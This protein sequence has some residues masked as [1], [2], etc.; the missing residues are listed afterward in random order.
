MTGVVLLVTDFIFGTI[1]TTIATTLLTLLFAM[2][3]Y[4]IPYRRRL[5]LLAAE[6][7]QAEIQ[8]GGQAERV[9]EGR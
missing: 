7:K 2:L 9:P 6:R 8:P 3:W 5:K 4:I 1:A